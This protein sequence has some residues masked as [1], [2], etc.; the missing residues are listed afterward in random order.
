MDV[1]HALLQLIQA[2]GLFV[3][4]IVRLIVP[5]TPLI[6]WVAYWMFAVDWVR[7]RSFLL[8]G[9]WVGVLLIAVMAILVWGVVAPPPEGAHHLMGLT[10]S[11]F[12]GKTIYVSAL[13]VIM[14]L[15]G[16]VQLSGIV[17]PWLD[18]RQP[19]DEESLAEAHH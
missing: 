5:W 8:Q 6:A 17:D 10:V 7:L 3:W 11:N 16:S 4:E 19:S 12:V 13:V 18:L 15:S 2:L 9:G 14:L 1:L